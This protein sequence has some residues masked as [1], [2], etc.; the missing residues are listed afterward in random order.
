MAAFPTWRGRFGAVPMVFTHDAVEFH[1]K[2]PPITRDS[3]IAL[4]ID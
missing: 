2:T 1:D 3:A 4:A